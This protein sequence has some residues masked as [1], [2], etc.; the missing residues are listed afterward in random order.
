VLFSLP[1]CHSAAATLMR[2]AGA[3]K[4]SAEGKKLAH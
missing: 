1:K 2:W 4:K 3:Q